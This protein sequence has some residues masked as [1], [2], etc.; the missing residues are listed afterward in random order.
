MPK[1]ERRAIWVISHGPSCLDGV[2]AAAAVRRFY[3]GERI[4]A[5]LAANGD[6]DRVIQGIKRKSAGEPEEIWI[7]DLSW[8]SADTAAHLRNLISDGARLYWI[9]HHRTAVSRANAAE[10]DVP[11]TGRV[12]SE[13]YSAARLTFNFLKRMAE[14]A[15]DEG[16]AH[17]YEKFFPFVAI[18]DDHDRWI[19]RIPESADWALAVQTLGGIE[20]YREIIRLE[21]PVMSRRLRA[22]L[23]M[24]RSALD[25]SLEIAR[26]TMMDRA[27][28]N[29]LRV[30]T[31]CCIGYSSEVASKLYEDQSQTII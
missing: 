24:G 11:F 2:M 18:A 12:L 9:D 14:E 22:A 21:E 8:T 15:G 7:T 23:E 30:R 13:E 3:Q 26:A 25:K 10:F 5:V 31:A 16:K 28:G 1:M 20:S 6:S 17:D 27:L 4:H 29:G 19:H